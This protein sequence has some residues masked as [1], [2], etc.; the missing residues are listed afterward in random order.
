MRRRRALLAGAALA[1]V[2]A[3]LMLRS[4]R[5]PETRIE[6]AFDDGAVVA[7]EPDGPDGL[8]LRALAGELRRAFA[9]P[10]D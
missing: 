8:E 2:G 10:P 7:V 9:T 6:L 4:R 3:V 5:G 1:S